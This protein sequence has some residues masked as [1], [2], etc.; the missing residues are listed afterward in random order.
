ML[1]T[2]ALNES[3]RRGAQVSTLEV[4]A[5]NLVAQAL[6]RD[7]GY[8]VINRRKHYYAD[9]GEDALLMLLSDLSPEYIAWLEGDDE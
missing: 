5:S 9:N 2:E 7:F 3:V 8:D 4:R 6:Y 1:L